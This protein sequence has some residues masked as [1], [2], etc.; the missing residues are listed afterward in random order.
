MQVKKWEILLFNPAVCT[1][2]SCPL[3]LSFFLPRNVKP[4]LVLFFWWCEEKNSL[5]LSSVFYPGKSFRLIQSFNDLLVSESSVTK[6][7]QALQVHI[8]TPSSQSFFERAKLLDAARNSLHHL[9]YCM[10]Y[11][12]FQECTSRTCTSPYLCIQV[13][14]INTERKPI[15]LP[16]QEYQ[17]SI[18]LSSLKSS[19]GG[20]SKWQVGSRKGSQEAKQLSPGL[21]CPYTPVF[22]GGKHVPLWD[23]YGCN[24]Q[25][26]NH[27]QV[28]EARLRVTIEGVVQPWYKA[29]HY[30]ECNARIIQPRRKQKSVS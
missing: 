25:D 3:K 27:N 9:S 7:G 20:F 6:K 15:K 22:R 21:T 24:A 10:C 17:V 26:T 5:Y 29:A 1:F 13:G 28:D 11:C 8:H 14:T 19:Q 30:E 2:H 23:N 12:P 16:I 4:N 18:K